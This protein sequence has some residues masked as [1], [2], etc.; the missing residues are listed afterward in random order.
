MKKQQ[1]FTLIELMIVVAIIGILASVAI[2]QYR[3][4]INRTE[5]STQ[6]LAAIRPVQ[7][8]I[9]EYAATYNKLPAT[10]LVDLVDVSFS[11]STG[12]AYAP[13]QLASGDIASIDVGADGV[14]TA[15]FSGTTKSAELISKTVIITPTLSASGAVVF[16]VTGGTLEA[17]YRPKL[18]M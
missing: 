8:A 5:A 9:S 10:G 7:N 13:A 18:K 17:K 11:N 12:G 3:T 16:D 6:V 14:I 4:Y 2:P 1:G 15:T